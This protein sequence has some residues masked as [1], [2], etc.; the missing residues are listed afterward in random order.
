MVF[1][2]LEFIFRLVPNFVN[3]KPALFIFTDD[4]LLVEQRLASLVQSSALTDPLQLLNV[5]PSTILAAKSRPRNRFSQ[6]GE[7][8]DAPNNGEVASFSLPFPGYTADDGSLRPVNIQQLISGDIMCARVH[9]PYSIGERKG[10]S[11]VSQSSDSN[12]LP[13]MSQFLAGS[14]SLALVGSVISDGPNQKVRQM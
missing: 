11:D 9:V 4:M 7:G 5:T 10:V 1:V 14:S 6:N 3:V 12:P 2:Q 13:A 8:C